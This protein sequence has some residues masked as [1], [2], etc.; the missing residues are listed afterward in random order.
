MS[1]ESNG[2]QTALW[3]LMAAVVITLVIHM[4]PGLMTKFSDP[5][6]DVTE[7]IMSQEIL[8][9][10]GSFQVVKISPIADDIVL[11]IVNAGISNGSSFKVG[12]L[13]N[14]HYEIGKIVEALITFHY[15]GNEKYLVHEVS[16][17]K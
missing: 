11:T 5:V 17:L 3:I 15:M 13:T 7:A 14:V 8:M 6:Q 16:I 9:V 12:A 2:W 10:T 1:N 4:V